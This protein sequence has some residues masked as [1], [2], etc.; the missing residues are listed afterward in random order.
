MTSVVRG[1][2]EGIGITEFESLPKNPVWFTELTAAGILKLP[3]EKPDIG[4]LL[5]VTVE[6]EIIYTHIVKTL[7]TSSNEGHKLAGVKLIIDLK[8][9]QKIKY[10]ADEPTQRVHSAN[11]E[12]VLKSIYVILPQ[13]HLDPATDKY[14]DVINLFKQGKLV[15]TPYIEDIYA[16]VQDK[17]TIYK[18][19]A[20]LIDVTVKKLSRW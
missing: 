17:R 10:T 8:L 4:Q 5:S 2:V 13:S 7:I 16:K 1:L 20:L 11:F 3:E 18:N 15:A 19:I 14:F 6:P 9:R 12:N